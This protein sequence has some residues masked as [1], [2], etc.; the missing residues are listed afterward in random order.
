MLPDP[1]RSVWVV[2]I[3]WSA[4]LQTGF[5][6]LLQPVVYTTA[7]CLTINLTMPF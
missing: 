6:D 1:S 7:I 3:I 5:Q 2:P 4:V